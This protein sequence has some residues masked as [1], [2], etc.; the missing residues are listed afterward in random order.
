MKVDQYPWGTERWFVLGSMN[1]SAAFTH[2][3]RKSTMFLP[4]TNFLERSIYVERGKCEVKTDSDTLILEEGSTFK[5]PSNVNVSVEA[6]FGDVDLIRV[7]SFNNKEVS[8][9]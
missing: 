1:H 9:S 5:V 4:S 7:C 8:L 6:K 2:I 3:N